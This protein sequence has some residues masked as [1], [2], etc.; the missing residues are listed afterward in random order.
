MAQEHN[1]FHPEL[2]PEWFGDL[3]AYLEGYYS[4]R[5]RDW[6]QP[7]FLAN[8]AFWK[9]RLDWKQLTDFQRQVL[10]VVAEIPSGAQMTYGQVAARI[11]KPRASRAV[12]AAVGRNPWPVLVPCH[13]VLGQDGQMTGFSAPGGIATK[14]R[15]LELER[16]NRLFH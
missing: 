8:W 1:H 9:P 12:G 16:E 7:R 4:C 13:R 6:T 15:M 11:G 3:F 5:L 2:V 14:R 10:E